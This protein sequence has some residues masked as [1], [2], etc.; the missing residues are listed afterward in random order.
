VKYF[1][2]IDNTSICDSFEDSWNEDSDE[3][4]KV[5][6]E[7]NKPEFREKLKQLEKEGKMIDLQGQADLRPEIFE[8]YEHK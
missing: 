5:S 7:Q 3:R 4:L 1:A 2:F 8:P 6:S